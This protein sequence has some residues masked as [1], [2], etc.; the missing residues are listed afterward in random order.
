MKIEFVNPTE[1]CPTFGWTHVVSN[2]GGKTIHI[3][4]Q[5]AVVGKVPG[6]WHVSQP[7]ASGPRSQPGF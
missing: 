1:L 7:V 2:R 6:A 4:G 3:S 5:V